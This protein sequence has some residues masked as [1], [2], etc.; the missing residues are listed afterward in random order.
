M[1]ETAAEAPAAP[2][3][4]QTKGEEAY[5]GEGP[6]LK[7]N[8]YVKPEMEKLA[9]EKKRIPI[10][11]HF[12]ERQLKATSLNEIRAHQ[13]QHGMHTTSNG[14]DYTRNVKRW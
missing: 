4:T 6:T 3:A 11:D 14:V 10:P 7:P 13:L 8:T 1:S 5:L 2:L 12:A 9:L